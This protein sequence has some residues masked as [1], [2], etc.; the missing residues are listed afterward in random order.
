[1][2]AAV[3]PVRRCLIRGEQVGVDGV[4]LAED[5]EQVAR[6]PEIVV[7][8]PQVLVLGPVRQRPDDRVQVTHGPRPVEASDGRLLWVAVTVG[9]RGERAEE[10]GP[11]GLVAR[12]VQTPHSLR[13]DG[14]AQLLQRWLVAAPV[15]GAVADQQRNV[16]RNAAARELTPSELQPRR[17]RRRHLMRLNDH[18]ERFHHATRNRRTPAALRRAIE[19]AG[20]MNS[21]DWRQQNALGPHG[22][23]YGQ[24]IRKKL[25]Y[26]GIAAVYG[27]GQTISRGKRLREIHPLVPPSE[28][29]TTARRPAAS[30]A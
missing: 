14:R 30:A 11:D 17:Q 23:R 29:T 9:Q 4:K 13:T 7:Q 15:G 21:R 19:S 16:E 2:E 25:G 24:P 3:V 1:M 5:L 18:R 26:L 6:P 8:N 20:K 12:W 22:A 28:V 10:L 27:A